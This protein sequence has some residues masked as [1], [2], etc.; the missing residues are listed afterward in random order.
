MIHKIYSKIYLIKKLTNLVNCYLISNLIFILFVN[1]AYGQ[2]NKILFKVNNNIITTI[3][4]LN[5]VNYLKSVNLEFNKAEKNIAYE[6]AKNSIIKEKIKEIEIL[7]LVDEIK[8]DEKLLESIIENN[9]SYLNIYS[10]IEFNDYFT[11][12]KIDPSFIKKRLSIE[13][14]W[15]QI[16][17]RK[18]SD[19][20]KINVDEIRKKL[21]NEKQEELFISEILF[22]LNDGEELS[23]KFNLIKKTI[24]EKNF[25]Q[26]ALIFSISDSAKNGGKIGWLKDTAISKKILKKLKNINIGDL[27][28]P[29]V[30]PGGF[31][32][33]KIEDKRE[34]NK[35]VNL[36]KEIKKIIENKTNQQLN[37]FSNI[38][39]N[40]IKKNILINEL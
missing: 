21:L 22:E 4:I 40:K 24:D 3:D 26:A 6:I 18:F 13:I 35:N 7:K 28:E 16:I 15:N 9:F 34:V 8:V 12:K 23:Q 2:E 30:V 39:F 20:I 29:L 19:K 37:Q 1:L 27:S 25:S 32:I 14:L 5:E 36:E 17:Y 11:N 33:L 31:L 38:Y 10:K